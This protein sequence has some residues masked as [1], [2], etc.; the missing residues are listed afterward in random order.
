MTLNLFVLDPS[1]VSHL[2]QELRRSDVAVLH[3]VALPDTFQPSVA[4][5][6]LLRREAAVEI[7]LD[8]YSQYQGQSALWR[9]IQ[10][11]PS[12]AGGRF[13]ARC[14]GDAYDAMRLLRE[15]LLEAG[16]AIRLDTTTP[17]LPE[18]GAAQIEHSPA[19]DMTSPL[20]LTDLVAVARRQRDTL[21]GRERE[22]RDLITCLLRE[23]KPGVVLV[24][25]PG[26][27][28]TALVTILAARIARGQV[29]EQLRALP[30]YEL[31]LGRLLEDARYAGHLE[32]QM[33][34][35]L[36]DH[37]PIFFIDEV[38]QLARQELQ[39]VADLLK[40]ALASGQIRVIAATTPTEWRQVQDRA[41][42]RRF[43]QIDLAEP[44][45]SETFAILQPRAV[46]LSDHHRVRIT[47]A[48]L[49]EVIALAGR[50]LQGRAFPDKAV[51]LLD[52][53]G[54]MQAV[55]GAVLDTTLAREH[56]LAAVAAQ[57]GLSPAYLDPARRQ[58]EVRETLHDLREWLVGQEVAL[59]ALERMLI[60]R[61]AE[62]DLDYAGAA[63]TLT[64]PGEDAHRPLACV[65]AVGPTGVGKTATAR[66]LATRLF[67]GRLIVLNGGDVGPEAPH[68]VA[69]WVGAP[70]GYVGYNQGGVLTDGLRAHKAG[71]V[72]IDELEKAAPEAIQ[73]ILLPLLGAGTVVDR[74][75]GDVLAAGECIVFATSNLADETGGEIGFGPNASD[76]ESH[77]RALHDA[78]SHALRPELIGRFNAVLH[79]RGLTQPEKWRI[80]ERELARLGARRASGE[81]P[82]LDGK[83]RDWITTRLASVRTGA[84]GVLDLFRAT[85]LQAIALTPDCSVLTHNDGALFA[86]PGD[87]SSEG[88]EDDTIHEHRSFPP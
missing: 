59:T 61:L 70:P 85:V 33:R 72:L 79:Y 78:L 13:L 43:T 51:D 4:D 63:A 2:D 32:R 37:G 58:N 84:R 29:P 44:S 82:R 87:R 88:G 41:F 50:Y 5:I 22:L 55:S 46:S 25:P 34:E 19:G 9:E 62:R 21:V 54:A 26:C 28:K 60:T 64:V 12:Q 16:G 77:E 23:S 42:R 47:D 31:P 18:T 7:Y 57:A 11:R 80:W 68:G 27:G 74:N 20:G 8:A 66:F 75:N 6:A 86:G 24:G 73:N 36:H 38:H 81:P 69:T 1:V 83:A 15:F 35:V 45:P 10:T 39:P 14:P 17:D 49:R 56:L 3:M 67:G 40:P 65:L 71:V 52:H 48:D 30:L 76:P 53:A